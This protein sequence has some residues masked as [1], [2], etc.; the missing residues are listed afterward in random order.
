[1][2]YKLIHEKAKYEL[3]KTVKTCLIAD[4]KS[5]LG[6][7]TRVAYKR[8]K[9]SKVKYPCPKRLFRDWLLYTLKF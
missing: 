8:A 1:M 6:L 9:A 5:E 7:T 2:T 3:G 4:I